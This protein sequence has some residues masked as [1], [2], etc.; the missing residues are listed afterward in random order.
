[1]STTSVIPV[2]K[3]VIKSVAKPV[4]KAVTNTGE[5]TGVQNSVN[6]NDISTC[7]TKIVTDNLY[8]KNNAT[9]KN[10][11]VNKE[12]CLGKNLP[13]PTAG[14]GLDQG[15]GLRNGSD[16]YVNV[17]NEN[18]NPYYSKNARYNF[19][20]QIIK[21]QTYR[22]SSS[23]SL[24]NTGL[25]YNKNIHSDIMAKKYEPQSTEVWKIPFIM[26]TPL[27]K[28]NPDVYYK[29]NP[30]VV[31]ADQKILKDDPNNFSGQELYK[32]TIYPPD[33]DLLISADTN[34]DTARFVAD[35]ATL[36]LRAKT[37]T[38]RNLPD[39]RNTEQLNKAIEIGQTDFND[40]DMRET[41]GDT[42]LELYVIDNDLTWP[43]T[44]DP[45]DQYRVYATSKKNIS[46]LPI[47]PVAAD[48]LAD[49]LNLKESIDNPIVQSLLEKDYNESELTLTAKNGI[50][51]AEFRVQY[52][53]HVPAIVTGNQIAGSV[54]SFNSIEYGKGY[55]SLP[56]VSSNYIRRIVGGVPEASKSGFDDACIMCK[57]IG[58]DALNPVGLS[59]TEL[60]PNGVIIYYA[61][62]GYNV[63]DNTLLDVEFVDV[64]NNAYASYFF[65]PPTGKAKI[66]GKKVVEVTITNVSGY[67]YPPCWAKINDTKARDRANI[68][69]SLN[70]SSVVWD[71]VSG[72]SGYTSNP[73]FTLEGGTEMT[74]A[75]A[76]ATVESGKIKSIKILNAGKGYIKSTYVSVIIV[77][78]TN[79]SNN[80][81]SAYATVSNGSI[82][83]I[84]ITNSGSAYSNSDNI[85]V[86]INGGRP[87]IFNSIILDYFKTNIS[88]IWFQL[89]KY[90][91][92]FTTFVVNTISYAQW[93]IAPLNSDGT[94][95]EAANLLYPGA[96]SYYNWSWLPKLYEYKTEFPEK[97]IEDYLKD[98][99]TYTPDRNSGDYY[100]PLVGSFD[101][102]RWALDLSGAQVMTEAAIFE[103]GIDY[104]FADPNTQSY[105]VN[106]ANEYFGTRLSENGFYRA[107]TKEDVYSTN[108][109]YKYKHGMRARAGK[110][111]AHEFGHTAGLNHTDSG[112]QLFSTGVGKN[113]D[114]AVSDLVLNPKN[115][116][117]MHI[118]EGDAFRHLKEDGSTQPAAYYN[119]MSYEP[120]GIIFTKEQRLVMR[121]FLSIER[122]QLISIVQ[123]SEVN[124]VYTD[125][126][127]LYNKNVLVDNDNSRKLKSFSIISD[128]LQSRKVEADNMIVNGLINAQMSKAELGIFDQ[129]VVGN[130]NTKIYINDN[131]HFVLGDIAIF[132]ENGCIKLIPASEDKAP[133]KPLEKKNEHLYKTHLNT[134]I[135]GHESKN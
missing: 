11:D 87:W 17:F 28:E 81:A 19:I 47:W 43:I 118:Y 101:K 54:K 102:K 67:L 120:Y 85:E 9:I 98:K 65:T 76:S 108:F 133:I 10:L 14:M 42:G 122:Q 8:V 52:R 91:K 51:S 100:K 44:K 45:T 90:P 107:A 7:P 89:T 62:S 33:K 49:A 6:K 72:G 38:I 1:M 130:G 106:E 36:Y 127:D 99:N 71:L 12:I 20:T 66:F 116:N 27:T 46:G 39:S 63:P 92:G 121:Y 77:D 115:P 69:L 119:I 13:T 131:G 60:D 134:H 83:S 75:R 50:A 112:D 37:K 74:F 103:S 61:G 126:L 78:K 59:A 70:G 114:F 79:S 23:V 117:F 15:D 31:K 40:F 93:D 84:T 132:N 30:F 80:S 5:S 95:N 88:S 57:T 58:S 82:S 128:K 104:Q 68:K 125:Y 24:E 29:Q 129:I 124:P 105:H 111:A 18:N 35:Q 94:F 2:I 32:N 56:K 53:S 96:E 64:N 16:L 109:S 21:N 73:V 3:P 4:A 25:Y 26:I 22:N 34:S 86:Q 110:I 55:T 135:H 41:M 113:D 48:K 97:T 123:S